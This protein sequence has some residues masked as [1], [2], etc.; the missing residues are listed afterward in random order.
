MRDV[1]AVQAAGIRTVV[2]AYGYLGDGIPIEDW[3]ADAVIGAPMELLDFIR[4]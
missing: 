3:G 4:P 1:Q 2:A